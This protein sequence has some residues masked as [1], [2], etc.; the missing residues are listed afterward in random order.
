[1]RKKIIITVFLIVLISIFATLGYLAYD[2]TEHNPNFCATCHIMEESFNKWKVSAHKGVNCHTCH[3]LPYAERAQLVV[4]FIIKRPHEIPPRHGKIIV[5]YNICF[6]CHFEGKAPKA[7][8]IS[9]TV[10]HKKHFFDERI[11]CTKCHGTKLHE[12]LPEEGFCSGCHKG[13]VIHGSV[14]KDFSCLT[15]H[16]FMSKE[17][18]SLIPARTV[19]LSCHKEMHP[20]AMFPEAADAIMR[21]NCNQCH[22]PHERI[23]PTR[24]QCYACHKEVKGYGLHKSENHQDCMLCHNRHTWTVTTRTACISC[25]KDMKAHMEGERCNICHGFKKEV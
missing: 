16:D 20:K 22:D 18:N 12:F 8:L 23:R 9:K 10:G 2:Y 14:M 7:E 17:V 24:F 25:H 11:E 19:C 13:I 21:F 1:M 4:S 3:Q 6:T 5:P 15:C